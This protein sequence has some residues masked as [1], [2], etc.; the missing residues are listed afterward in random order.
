MKDI[1]SLYRNAKT[2]GREVAISS[3]KEAVEELVQNH[4]FDYILQLEY[5]I[6]SEVGFSTLDSFL[7]RYGLCISACQLLLEAMEECVERCE[8]KKLPKLKKKYEDKQ[9]ELEKFQETYSHCCTMYDFY[10]DV[11]RAKEYLES[12]YGETD[13]VPNRYNVT[14][15][16]NTFGEMAV[17]DLLITAN[18]MDESAIVSVLNTLYNSDLL[19]PSFCETVTQSLRDLDKLQEYRE[20]AMRSFGKESLSTRIQEIQE[21]TSR[22]YREA[23]VL[24][25]YDRQIPMYESD[26]A[27]IHDAID[28]CEM[29]VQ[30]APDTQKAIDAYHETMELYGLLDGI[31]MENGDL[32][33]EDVAD[34]VIPM[35]PYSRAVKTYTTEVGTWAGSNHDAGRVPGYLAKHHNLVIG[36]E[37][38]SEEKEKEKQSPSEYERPNHDDTKKDDTIEPTH[39]DGDDTY[40]DDEDDEEMTPAE[41][42]R[43]INN[44][45]Y[46]TYTNSLNRNS[47][48]FNRDNDYSRH[49]DH[50]RT[51]INRDNQ[52]DS[53]RHHNSYGKGSVAAEEE[54]TLVEASNKQ[55]KNDGRPESDH[56]IR[57]AMMDIDRKAVGVGQKVKKAGQTVTQ[58]VKAATKPVKRVDQ[59]LNQAVEHWQTKSEDKIKEEMADP[60]HRKNLYTT[61]KQAI[62]NGSLLKAGLLL[63]PIFLMLRITNKQKKERLRTEMIGELKTEMEII[64]EKIKDAPDTPEGRRDKYKLMRFKNE[65]NKKLLRVGGHKGWSKWI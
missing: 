45:Y 15:M 54:S 62:V 4:P 57:D 60:H 11:D 50:H 33:D 36:E 18:H 14:K 29:A 26:I 61:I 52:Y 21:R 2:T 20:S 10:Q 25:E 42:R 19:N 35:L 22:E 8:E 64:D 23:V 46:Y 27:A 47:N 30:N 6:S 7:E 13:G 51:H 40:D 39:L 31:V 38:P 5:I 3:Y 28:L 55:V 56:P 65:L 1:R 63:N 48:S 9:K 49:D 12:Y 43:A 41:K 34:S 53:S 17:P 32:I 59:W 16:I 58:G 24:G 37:D 44:Y